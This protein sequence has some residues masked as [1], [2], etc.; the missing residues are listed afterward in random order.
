MRQIRK[1]T[2]T[3]AAVCRSCAW[4]FSSGAFLRRRKAQGCNSLQSGCSKSVGAHFS[5]SLDSRPWPIIPKGVES[6]SSSKS[7]NQG[8]EKKCF[9]IG[10]SFSFISPPTNAFT[11]LPSCPPYCL[12]LGL[13]SAGFSVSSSSRVL[14]LDAFGQV[15]CKEELVGERV[16]RNVE[17]TPLSRAATP[18]V[19]HSVSATHSYSLFFILSSSPASYSV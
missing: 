3:R 12:C 9:W 7:R 13:P 6:I 8:H 15:S 17:T 16:S 11:I 14:S 4:I 19:L 2:T 10:T 5:Q 18:T 1:P